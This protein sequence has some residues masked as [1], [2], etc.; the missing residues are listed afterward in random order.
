M[1]DHKIRLYR[2]PDGKYIIT[3]PVPEREGST[4]SFFLPARLFR[5]KNLYLKRRGWRYIDKFS[6][7]LKNSL[8]S[9]RSSKLSFC[10]QEFTFADKLTVGVENSDEITISFI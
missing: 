7:D 10:G 1:P 5:R 4:I 2:R 8:E 6:A 3:L 9:E